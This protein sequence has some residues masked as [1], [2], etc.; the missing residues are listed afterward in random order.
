[1]AYR[2]NIDI[3]GACCFTCNKLYEIIITYFRLPVNIVIIILIIRLISCQPALVPLL[4]GH[5]RI[6]DL[7]SIVTIDLLLAGCTVAH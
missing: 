1:M 2:F 6:L 7:Y 4:V 3:L 5:L